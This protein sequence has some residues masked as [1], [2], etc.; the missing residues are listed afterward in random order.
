MLAENSDVTRARHDLLG[1][2]SGGKGSD[3]PSNAKSS[4]GGGRDKAQT[5]KLVV[6][7]SVLVLAVAM[8]GYQILPSISSGSKP[9]TVVDITQPPDNSDVDPRMVTAPDPPRGPGAGKRANNK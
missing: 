7:I 3:A 4:K 9:N 6:A 2:P 1:G 8:I 5:V